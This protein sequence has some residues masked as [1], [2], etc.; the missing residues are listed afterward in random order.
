MP[1]PPQ[2]PGSVSWQSCGPSAKVE[3]LGA[4]RQSRRLRWCLPAVRLISESRS[5]ADP[6]MKPAELSDKQIIRLHQ[7]LHEA[8]FDDPD[9]Q[10]LSPAGAACCPCLLHQ[11]P[12]S[13]CSSREGQRFKVSW[14]DQASTTCGWAS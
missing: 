10:H 4:C 14:S 12:W 2:R 6:A 3:R 9:G 13:L 7:L 1:A 8:K 5:G 11:A